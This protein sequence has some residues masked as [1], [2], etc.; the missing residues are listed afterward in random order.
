[1]T[2]EPRRPDRLT[3]LCLASYVDALDLVK[4]RAK[5]TP[6]AETICKECQESLEA[7]ADVIFR[8]EPQAPDTH[9]PSQGA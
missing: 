9:H 1:M 5:D 3:T 6:I 2:L 7:L 8:P 4:H